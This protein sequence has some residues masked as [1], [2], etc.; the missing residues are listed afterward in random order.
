MCIAFLAYR[1][2]PGLP[3]ILLA[4][5]DEYY[6]RPSRPMDF[7]EELPHILAGRDIQAGGTWLGLTRY[8][9][10]AFITN[11]RGP[12]SLR[13]EAPSRGSLVADFLDGSCSLEAFMERLEREGASY[14]GFNMVFGT[15][16][17]LYYFSNMAPGF[18]RL[19]A[20]I[21][22]LS[23]DLLDTPWPKVTR[24]KQ[25]LGSLPPHSTAWTPERLFDILADR[26]LPPDETLPNT[27]MSLEWERILAPIF[28]YSERYGTR[29]GAVACIDEQ[30]N[31]MV[32][33]RN[34]QATPDRYSSRH[35]SLNMAELRPRQEPI[36]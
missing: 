11:Y 8:G 31:A 14:N 34:Y 21:Y 36:N 27:G 10:L 24:G 22:G 26:T 16:S 28:I 6:H 29:S 7:W 30:G 4:N 13:D 9:R 25:R 12:D 19:E 3:L 17:R 5:R 2:V 1:H 32:E 20:G 18:H 15:L 33:E 23:N 35:F